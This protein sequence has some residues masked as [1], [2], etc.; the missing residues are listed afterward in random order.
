[1]KKVFLFN[2]TGEMAIAND[3]A[4]YT[5]PAFL[6]KFEADVAPLL[7]FAGNGSDVLLAESSTGAGAFR[8][9]WHSLG[10]SLPFFT[11]LGEL[12]EVLVGETFFPVPW[13]WNKAVHRLLKPLSAF[14]DDAFLKTPNSQWK[15]DYRGFFSR[16]TSVR[17]LNEVKEV[18]DD[19]DFMS[20][21]YSPD[22]VS[23]YDGILQWMKE[24]SPPYVFKTP[25]SSSG[26]G[27]YP[28][29]DDEFARRC[30]IWVKS[31]VKQQKKMIIEPWLNRLQDLSF[32]FVIEEDGNV[33]FLGVNF[34]EAGRVG[35]F[36]KE[37]IGIPDE[38]KSRLS[39]VDM[40]ENRIE[41][42]AGILK[43][44]LLANKYH[45][46]YSGP[47]GIDAMLFKNV[48]GDV[49]LHP[50]IEINFRLNMG[51]VNLKLKDILHPEA[52]GEWTIRQFRP[53]EWQRFANE[54]MEAS[55]VSRADGAIR[56]GFLPLVPVTKEQL[57]GA[58]AEI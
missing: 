3:T 28:V 41:E 27:L 17:F 30:L 37:F 14:F 5:P 46:F 16:E 40:P 53:G 24:H 56:K 36:K 25:W 45:L 31:R 38:L 43:Q 55:P 35:D 20:I 7:A 18:I 15:E 29:T 1:M 4:S 12:P 23:G 8:E 49:R 50:C 21:P 47:I 19:H 54:R 51:Y 22:V 10:V 42:A 9:F 44:V 57:Y 58:W 26:R 2:P 52:K 39:E 32:Q 6:R 48:S 13:G 34:F 11:K 33:K